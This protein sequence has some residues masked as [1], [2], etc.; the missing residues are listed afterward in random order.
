MT[1]EINDA[2]AQ[3]KKVENSTKQ[4]KK[5]YNENFQEYT[6]MEKETRQLQS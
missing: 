3:K 6:N 5:K 4:V 1:S 2:K